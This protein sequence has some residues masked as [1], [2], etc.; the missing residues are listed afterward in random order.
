M[1]E[2][3]STD[4][5]EKP[6]VKDPNAASSDPTDGKKMYE[7]E[8]RYP[9]E[10]QKQ[11]FIEGVYLLAIHIAAYL[12]IFLAWKGSL[13][14]WLGLVSPADIQFKKI[15]YFGASGALG[16]VTFGIKYFYR[17]I[18]RGW[19]HQDRTAWRLKSPWV[20]T[21]VAIV[22]GAMIDSAMISSVSSGKSMSGYT[23]LAVGFLAG[24]FADE[25]VGK[26]YEVATVIFG[27]SSKPNG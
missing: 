6:N 7:W 19:W 16:G 13:S 27:R 12:I 10:A 18:A 22:V 2:T 1:T 3:N 11:M 17:V 15:V 14:S 26:M 23:V 24:Y 5:S 25:A 20:A 21:T 9:K 4:Q 8:S